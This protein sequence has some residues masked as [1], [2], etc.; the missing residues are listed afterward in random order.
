MA[1]ILAVEDDNLY[2]EALG[3][4]LRDEGHEFE[5]V[6]TLQDARQRLDADAFDLVLLDVAL[7]DGHGPTL[8]PEILSAGGPRVIC[9]TA[10]ADVRAVVDAMRAGAY[11]YVEKSAK[12]PEVLERVRGALPPAISDAT[13]PELARELLG[14]SEPMDGVRRL[15]QLASQTNTTVLLRGDTGTGK[16]HIARLIHRHSP[17]ADR[18]FV[19]VDCAALSETLAESQLFGHERGSFTGAINRH[20]GAIESAGGGTLFFDEIADLPQSVQGKLLRVLEDRVFARVG[21]GRELPVEARIVGATR[22]DLTEMVEEG[23]FRED[24]LFRLTVLEVPLPPLR[25]RAR[26]VPLLLEHFLQKEGHDPAEVQISPA[27]TEALQAHPFPGNVREL[28][29]LVERMLLMHRVH[30]RCP[31]AQELGVGTNRPRNDVPTR[32]DLGEGQ[33]HAEH[34]EI[35][36]AL[37]ASGGRIGDAA[38]SLGMSRHALRRKLQKMQDDPHAL[39]PARKASAS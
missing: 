7:P 20:V 12:P 29:N 39:E 27:L 13:D 18:P 16:S 4:F 38:R 25:E 34:R 6:G 31:T 23:R 26:D 15:V 5:R 9:L 14:E 24:L 35:G 2:G 28:R 22:R 10:F 21:G 33:P 11:D 32:V 1:H 37:V 8:I 17:R 30:G 3:E 36:E 19:T